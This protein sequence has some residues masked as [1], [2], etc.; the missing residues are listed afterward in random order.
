MTGTAGQGINTAFRG[1]LESVRKALTFFKVMAVVVGVG[2]LLLV[3]GVVLRYGFDH[4]Q[5]SKV[6]SPIHGFLYLVYLV[7]T[8][9]LGSRLRWPLGKIVLV[10][11]AGTIPFLSFVAEQKVSR[12]VEAD[13]TA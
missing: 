9:L 3:T 12:Q 7:A 5:L 13:L 8:A 6:W 2:L 1:S 11:L 4:P 10:A